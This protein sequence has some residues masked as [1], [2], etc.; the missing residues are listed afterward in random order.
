MTFIAGIIIMT[1]S[2]Y[3]EDR[4]SG[5]TEKEQREVERASFILLY[6][7]MNEKNW[8]SVMCDVPP[9]IMSMIVQFDDQ[10]KAQLP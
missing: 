3:G 4:D 10:L 7:V 8:K 9:R 6:Y 2:H 1:F 5:F